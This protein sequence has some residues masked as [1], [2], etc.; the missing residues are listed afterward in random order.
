MSRINL[1]SNVMS[2][3]IPRTLW[4]YITLH[5][6]TQ[7]HGWKIVCRWTLNKPLPFRQLSKGSCP[8]EG[9]GKLYSKMLDKRVITMKKKEPSGVRGKSLLWTPRHKDPGINGTG[10]SPEGAACVGNWIRLLARFLLAPI[11]FGCW[12]T[13]WGLSHFGHEN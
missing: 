4:K 8:N 13:M 2:E 1:Q 6:R 3:S 7:N 5:F 10:T 12:C 11:K 9:P